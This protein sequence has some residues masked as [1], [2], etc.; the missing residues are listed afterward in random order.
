MSCLVYG[1]FK[2][3]DLCY[4]N[5]NFNSDIESEEDSESHSDLETLTTMISIT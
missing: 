5:L 4:G 2:G 3:C 1:Y